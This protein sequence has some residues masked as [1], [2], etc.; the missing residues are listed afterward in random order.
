MNQLSPQLEQQ[1]KLSKLLGLG[2]AFSLVSMGGIGSLLA[3]IIGFK[4][5]RYILKSSQQLSGI[6]M[7]WWCIIVGILGALVSIPYLFFTVINM[8]R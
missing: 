7:A 4:S 8:K 3:L 2:F 5:R 1:I 6:R